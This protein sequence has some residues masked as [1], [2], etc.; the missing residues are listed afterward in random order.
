[1]QGP[2][3]GEHRGMNPERQMEMM[4][5]RLNLSDAQTAKIRDIFSDARMKMEA[6]RSNSTLSPEDRRAQMMAMHQGAQE[7]IRA[8][9]NPEQQAKYDEMQQRMRGTAWRRGNG[10]G[11]SSAAA[12]TSSATVF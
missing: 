7:K 10:R 3:R 9:L 5:R 6:L 12:S 11:Q 8:V 4:Q 1:M 2:M